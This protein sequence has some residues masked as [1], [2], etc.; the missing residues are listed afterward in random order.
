MS[1]AP[2]GEARQEETVAEER[3]EEEPGP[4][5][6]GSES[7]VFLNKKMTKAEKVEESKR[8]IAEE[9]ESIATATV[10]EKG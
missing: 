9:C 3:V 2:E 6:A 8:I 5:R 7:L 1:S 4:Q 10:A